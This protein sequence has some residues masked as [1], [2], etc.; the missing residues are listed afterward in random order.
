MVVQGILSYMV[1]KMRI[2]LFGY[3]SAAASIM[4]IVARTGNEII[5]LVLPSNR[6]G[7]E[8]DIAREAARRRKIEFLFQPPNPPAE[9]FIVKLQSFKPDLGIVF[10]YSQIL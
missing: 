10:S 8:I 2:I 4:D 6:K 5:A 3:T 7:P 9:D 1:T